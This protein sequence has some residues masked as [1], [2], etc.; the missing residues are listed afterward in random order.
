MR[1]LIGAA[2]LAATAATVCGAQ[3][4]GGPHPAIDLTE[5]TIEELMAI[6]VI[7]VSRRPLKLAD[8]AAAVCALT[9]EDIRRSGATSLPEALRL[10][11]GLQVARYDA[12]KWALTSRGFN[13]LFANKL[14]VLIDGR[15]V[16]TPMFSGVFW[17]SQDVLLEDLEQLEVIRGPGAALWGANAVNGI[18]NVRTRH[19]V[20]TQGA[21]VTWGTGTEE[22]LFGSARFGGR[23]RKDLYYRVYG[24]YFARDNS[25][26]RDDFD[27]A[28]AAGAADAW[29]MRRAGFRVDWDYSDR[30]ALRLT[31]DAVTGTVGQLLEIASLDPRQAGYRELDARMSGGHLMGRWERALPGASHLALQLYYDRT[32]RDDSLLAGGS[33]DNYDIDFQHGVRR[34]DHQILWGAGYRLTRDDVE[35]TVTAWFGKGE[36]TYHLFSAFVQD[37][38]DIVARRLRLTLGSKFEHHTFSGLEIQPNARLLWTPHQRHVAWVAVARAVRTPARV[39]HDMN[40]VRALLPA[41]TMHSDLPVLIVPRGDPRFQSEVDR[42]VELGYRV[43]AAPSLFLDLATFA[44]SYDRLLTYELGDAEEETSPVPHFVLPIIADNKMAGDTHGV[45]VAADWLATD[46]WRLRAGYT[47]LKMDLEV[48]PDSNSATSE[49]SE[50]DSPRHQIVLSSV[51]DLPGALELDLVGRYVDELPGQDIDSYHDLEVR[52]GWRLRQDVAVS[53]SGQNLL[54]ESHPEFRGVGIPIVA[55]QAERGLYGKVILDW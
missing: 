6:E 12:N 2:L 42:A 51:L 53:V 17:E 16:Y 21:Q 48:D 8:A 39:D 7:T 38:L 20:D 49:G 36:R 9:C 55:T 43:Q 27:H 11:P 44:N 40:F 15:S 4:P 32:A 22:R 25:V 13:N 30:D 28:P 10:A 3:A 54:G 29:A 1:R 45:E 34:G 33:H 35:N 46:G 5:L 50:R 23:L 47:Y 24:K 19:A 41:G 26:Y 31:G 14:Q 37:D 18:V 52:V